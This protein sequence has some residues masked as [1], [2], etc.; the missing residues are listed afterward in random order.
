MGLLLY[1]VLASV[2]IL[3][4]ILSALV[5][6]AGGTVLLAALTLFLP[7]AAVIPVHGT[8]QLV[9]NFSRAFIL[10]TYIHKKIF[11]YFLLGAPLGAFASTLLIKYIVSTQFLFGL[12]VLLILYTVFKPER[13]PSIMLKYWQFSI[14]GFVIG[15][16][17]LLIGATGPLVSV[18]F[19]RKDLKKEEIVATTASIQIL[20]HVLKI[21][22]FLYLGFNYLEYWPLIMVMLVGAIIGTQIGV[23]FLNTMHTHTFVFLY[24]LTLLFI[25][26]YIAFKNI[27]I[28]YI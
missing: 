9:S 13:L 24:K 15:F 27:I 16:L 2:A 4:S 8:V 6:M 1:F 25:A 23:K 20:T 28:H 5:G 11:C 22:A 18:F 12:I 21:P 19:L 17:G 10:R 14:L 3:T 26:T 7:L